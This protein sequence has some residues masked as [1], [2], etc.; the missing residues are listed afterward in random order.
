MKVNF[1]LP[2]SSIQI[3]T[4]KLS[5]ILSN[6]MVLYVK[7]L[8]CHWNME[9]PRFFFLHE[10]FEKQYRA[11]AE[12][13]DLLAERIRSMG[14]YPPASMQEF[15]KKTTLP[16]ISK[17]LTGNQMIKE[18]AAS[19]EAAIL[20]LRDL[21]VLADEHGDPG[22]NDLASQILRAHE[23]NAWFLRSHL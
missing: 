10:L 2:K 6:T 16:E 14:A 12:D 1:G 8:H 21:I 18:L 19:H 17:A 22:L 3:L 23:K 13:G 5:V 15:L 4:D 11:L 20:A 9:D 7:T